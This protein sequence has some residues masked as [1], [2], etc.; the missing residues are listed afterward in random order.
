MNGN[1]KVTYHKRIVVERHIEVSKSITDIL[2]ELDSIRLMNYG[3][4]ELV[5]YHS[6]CS[7]EPHCVG[8]IFTIDLTMSEYNKM[9]ETHI[10]NDDYETSETI[11]FIKKNLER[12]KF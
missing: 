6:D 9:K 4:P 10:D 7:G 12:I 11:K 2:K 1:S 5:A 8:E 3:K